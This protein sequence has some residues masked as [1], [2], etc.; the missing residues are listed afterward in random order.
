M[1][2]HVVIALALHEIIRFEDFQ[3]IKTNQTNHANSEEVY[4]IKIPKRNPT[5]LPIASQ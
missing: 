5:A 1:S 4:E 2:I 3:Q